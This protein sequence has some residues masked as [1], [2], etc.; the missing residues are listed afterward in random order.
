M[1]KLT[2]VIA[3]FAS[4]PI[5]AQTAPVAT[6]KTL[7][8]T[9]KNIAS[10]EGKI[11]VGLY[12]KKEAFLEKEFKMISSNPQLGKDIVIKFTDLPQGEYT[13]SVMHDLNNNGELDTNLIG[14]PTEPY[15][16]SMT[17]KNKYGP[18][19]YDNAKFQ[20]SGEDKNIVISL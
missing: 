14:M 3:L 19:S 13:V 4:A 16:I 1:K 8:V 20:I 2:L 12:N 15:G 17:G 5:F 10:S 6:G 18:P 9:V 7:E 11:M